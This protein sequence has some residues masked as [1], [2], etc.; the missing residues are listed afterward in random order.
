[1]LFSSKNTQN[2]WVTRVLPF[3]CVQLA[4]N[5][6]QPQYHSVMSRCLLLLL[7]CCCFSAKNHFLFFS[8]IRHS[9]T[10]SIRGRP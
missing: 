10:C 2:P 8:G 1:L 5:P 7:P 3:P 4:V 6:P 9:R